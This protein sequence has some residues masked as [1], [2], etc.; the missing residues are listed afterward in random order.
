MWAESWNLKTSEMALEV[1]CSRVKAGHIE[2]PLK[3][4]QVSQ[5]SMFYKMGGSDS[6]ILS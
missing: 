3:L 4:Y 2:G 1:I 5:D 6:T